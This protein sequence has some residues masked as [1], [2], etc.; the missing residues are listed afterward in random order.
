[1][2]HNA[3]TWVGAFARRECITRAPVRFLWSFGLGVLTSQ[4][5][6][7]SLLAYVQMA[8]PLTRPT[9]QLVAEVVPSG[10]YLGFIQG[11]GSQKPCL[12]EHQR[13]IWRYDQAQDRRELFT[14][15]DFNPPPRLW[16]GPTVINVRL[17]PD[18]PVG[19]YFYYR[20]TQ[21]WCSWLNVLTGHPT[22]EQ[23]GDVPFYVVSPQKP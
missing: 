2:G 5:V 13:V 10:G 11:S 22:V 19:Q 18:L 12:Q 3:L 15:L 7:W 4:M 8:E 23:T 20:Q 6:I 16:A 17:P 1:M 9:Q 14:L 21:S